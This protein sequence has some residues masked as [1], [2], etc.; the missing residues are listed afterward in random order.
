MAVAVVLAR[1]LPVL[2]RLVKVRTEVPD[3]LTL[4]LLVLV[5]AAGVAGQVLLAALQQEQVLELECLV[6]AVMVCK[7]LLPEQTLITQAVV[8]GVA[9]I[10]DRL[11]PLVKEAVALEVLDQML[12]AARVLMVLEV[13]VVVEVR[14]LLVMVVGAETAL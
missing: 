8:L 12:R 7:M 9:G 10:R 11:E 1:H 3:H 2:V 14:G 6:R 4:N 5:M 13:V